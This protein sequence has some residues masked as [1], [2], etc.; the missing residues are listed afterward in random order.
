[1]RCSVASTSDCGKGGRVAQ[2]REAVPCAVRAVR[3]PGEEFSRAPITEAVRQRAAVTFRSIAGSRLARE[4]APSR[5]TRSSASLKFLR[6]RWLC[7]PARRGRDFLLG[8]GT[9]TTSSV[10]RFGRF[11]RDDTPPTVLLSPRGLINHSVSR[12]VSPR[13]LDTVRRDGL[14]PDPPCRGGEPCG[15]PR[16]RGGARPPR[17][18]A[19]CSIVAKLPRPRALVASLLFRPRVLFGDASRDVPRRPRARRRGRRAFCVGR[20]RHERCGRGVLRVLR[21]RRHRRRD[22]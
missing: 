4:D 5:R 10:R 20:G 16:A 14:R 3:V 6:C 1:M 22:E 17:R 9:T 7:E 15:T 12:G 19:R 13:P 8:F 2:V 21:L 18:R 11:G